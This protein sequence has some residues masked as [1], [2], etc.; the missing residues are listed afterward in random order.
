M[1]Q[2]FVFKFKIKRK[3]SFYFLAH[4][5]L[6]G[7]IKV[8]F[9]LLLLK[10]FETGFEVISLQLLEYLEIKTLKSLFTNIKNNKK[11]TFEKKKYIKTLYQ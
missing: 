7:I 4:L 1:D 6:V 5:L 3:S 10:I 8:F 2:L 9:N 11:I